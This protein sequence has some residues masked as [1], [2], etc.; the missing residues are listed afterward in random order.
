MNVQ[1][2]KFPEASVARK[3][4]VVFPNG[5]TLPLGKPAICVTVGLGSQPSVAVGVGNVTGLP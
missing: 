4:T 3:V 5:K 2:V 1:L